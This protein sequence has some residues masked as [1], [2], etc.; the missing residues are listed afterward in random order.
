M[1][2]SLWPHEPQ[3]ARPPCPW[4]APW[5]Y[6][7]MSIVLEM[8]SNHLILCHPFIF[9]PSIFWS[10]RSFSMSQLFASGGQSISVSASTSI[11]PMKAQDWSPLGCTHWTS[12]QSKALSRLSSNITFQKYQFLVLN[13][14]IVKITHTYMTTWKTIALTRQTFVGKLMFMLFNMLSRLVITFL[15]MCKHF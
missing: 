12:L 3:H 6:P 15:P 13:F 7:L 2:N 1:S 4:P 8:L 10:I 5:V 11:L 9:L 14:F